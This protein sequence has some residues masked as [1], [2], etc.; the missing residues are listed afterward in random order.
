M[1]EIGFTSV[2]EMLKWV[3][4]V[5]VVKPPDSSL[6]MV[7]STVGEGEEGQSDGSE[8]EDSAETKVMAVRQDG[9][10]IWAGLS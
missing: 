9:R 10:S 7:F 5:R 3:P 4:G 1:E 2:G 6:V 8:E